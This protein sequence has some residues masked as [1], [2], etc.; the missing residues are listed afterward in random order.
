MTL[1]IT[2]LSI[3]AFSIA[4]IIKTFSIKTLGKMTLGITMLGIITFTI[5]N[6]TK[7]FSIKLS[8]Q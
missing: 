3:I 6:I 8:A 1:G 7:T 5:A 2:T 4:N